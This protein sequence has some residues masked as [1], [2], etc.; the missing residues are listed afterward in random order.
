MEGLEPRFYN[1]NK[2]IYNELDPI[3]EITFMLKGSYSVGFEINKQK[4]RVRLLGQGHTIG[5]YNC[6]FYKK[7]YFIW[8]CQEYIEGFA[9]GRRKWNQI[10]NEF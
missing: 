5:G 4:K 7:S 9:L 1:S 6:L 10:A 8:Y 3:L 2:I